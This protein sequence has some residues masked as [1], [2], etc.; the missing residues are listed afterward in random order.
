MGVRCV[1]RRFDLIDDDE[2]ARYYRRLSRLRM[3][4]Y[5]VEIMAG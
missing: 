5:R 2:G 3:R 4:W 1:S